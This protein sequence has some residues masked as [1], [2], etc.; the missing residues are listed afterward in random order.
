LRRLAEK[1]IPR[2]PIVT[3][4]ELLPAVKLQRV[5]Q[6]SL[7]DGVQMAPKRGRTPPSPRPRG[8]RPNGRK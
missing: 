3:P 7:K 8:G 1:I 5:A 4:G 2:V 6:V